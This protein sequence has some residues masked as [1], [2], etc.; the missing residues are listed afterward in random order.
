MKI[1]F[2]AMSGIR[3]CD[4]ELLELGLT[5]PGFVE[6]SKQIASLPSLGLL[7][8]AGMTPKRHD[9]HYLEVPDLASKLTAV[10]LNEKFDLVAI[11]SYSAQI[12]EAYELAM[13]FRTNGTP[14]VMG[15]T[16]VTAL[17]HEAQ[18]YCTSVVL[19]E[20]EP[21]WLEVL[22]DAEQEQLK[23]FYDARK[24]DYS[25]ADAP[26][27]A[28]ELLDISKY[29]RLTVQTSRGCP[30][31]CE[32]CAGSNLICNR[33]KQKPVEKVLAEIDRICKIWPHPF[34]EFADDNSFVDHAYWKALLPELK[35]RRIKWF[36]E[37]DLSVAEDPEL[38]RMMRESGCAQV[39]IGLESPTLDPLDGLELNGNWKLRRFAQY[40]EAIRTIQAH[41]ITV[42][43]CFIVG[44]DGQTTDV[45]DDIYDFVREAQ[46]Y[47]VQ[48]TILTPF[49]GT[50]LYD[51]LKKANRLIEPSNWKKCTLFDL[52]FRPLGM[53][54]KELRE[55]FHALAMKLYSDSFTNWRR[56]TFKQN[57]R[58]NSKNERLCA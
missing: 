56:D 35:K 1:A 46:L 37:T 13:R 14:V 38:L 49:P 48:I 6:R 54:G 34:I 57:L 32:F 4:T 47:E 24:L 45:F 2:I 18:K 58:N 19:G 12:D 31:N 33:Y 36:T 26:M 55:G 29:N 25:L 41:G 51:R 10:D 15:G 42:N 52:N 44:L 27:P 23:L 28:F 8:L 43:G 30:H 53:S 17:P 7:T 5:L 39:L 11:S 50:A 22:E 20:G 9:I 21:L 40:K 3:A 16:H